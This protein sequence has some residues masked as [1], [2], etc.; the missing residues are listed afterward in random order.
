MIRDAD[1]NSE[2]AK[3]WWACVAFPKLA[4]T[5]GSKVFYIDITGTARYRTI[6]TDDEIN[7]VI[8]KVR[9]YT[10]ETSEDEIEKDFPAIEY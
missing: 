1:D 8:A 3:T 2:S 10:A 7:E 5:T 9:S 6:E 4:G